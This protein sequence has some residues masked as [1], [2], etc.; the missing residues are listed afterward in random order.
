MDHIEDKLKMVAKENSTPL[1]CDNC[2]PLWKA[3]MQIFDKDV[4]KKCNSMST[5]YRHREANE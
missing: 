4:C 5:K 1:T 2:P 3:L